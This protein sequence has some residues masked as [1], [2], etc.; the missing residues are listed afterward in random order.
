MARIRSVHPDICESEVLASLD[1]ELERTFTRLWTYLDDQGRGKDDPRLI[2][3]A[4]YP[5]SDLQ[6]WEIVDQELTRLAES[7]LVIRWIRDGRKYLACRPESWDEYQHPQ[8]P[9]QSKC[10]TPPGYVEVDYRPRTGE[11][12]HSSGSLLDSDATPTV[13]VQE[14]YSPVVVDVVVDVTV[15]GEREADASSPPSRKDPILEE[16]RGILNHW[17]ENTIP[18]PVLSYYPE[19]IR[20]VAKF[21]RAG[22]DA[23]TIRKAMDELPGTVSAGTLSIALD[24]LKKPVQSRAAPVSDRN[25]D[26][27]LRISDA[28]SERQNA[29]EVGNGT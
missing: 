20:T 25:R 8:K 7:G 19:A 15:E 24:K 17:I 5:L 21:L 22:H 10:P 23:K 29:L 11:V 9:R 4:I 27:I 2:K 6:T 18:K 3:A 14:P 28:I 16:A 26:R 13:Q 1:A 12:T